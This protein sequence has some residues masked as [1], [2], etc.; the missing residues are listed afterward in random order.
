MEL[1]KGVIKNISRTKISPSLFLFWFCENE[2]LC[3]T[4]KTT[5]VQDEEIAKELTSVSIFAC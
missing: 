3:N 1:N 2:T 5:Y 4:K